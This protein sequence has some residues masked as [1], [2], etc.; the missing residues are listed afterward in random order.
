M[1]LEFPTK[2]MSRLRHS[3]ASAHQRRSYSSDSAGA[4]T[5]VSVGGIAVPGFAA[6]TVRAAPGRPGSGTA[7]RRASDKWKGHSGS[8]QCNPER[9][10]RL[11]RLPSAAWSTPAPV[12]L[13][14]RPVARIGFGAMQLPGPGVFG[15]PRDRAAAIA[16]LRRAVELGVDHIDTAQYYGPDVSNELIHARP[17]PVSGRPRHR[18]QGRGP[19]RRRGCVADRLRARP[20]CAPASRTTCDRSTSSR[21]TWSTSGYS[22]RANPTSSSTT[23]SA[24]WSSSAPKG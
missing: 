5:A 16:V 8:P 22:P 15:P 20:S 4:G 7:R 6:G 9:P 12:R 3:T 17:A 14:H 19:P 13:A 10:F 11:E 2:T 23:R 24:R 18:E 1:R 21:W